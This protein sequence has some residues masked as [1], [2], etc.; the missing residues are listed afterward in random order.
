MA[1]NP[2]VVTVLLGGDVMLGRGVDQILPHPGKPQLRERYMR[3]ATGHVRL[4]ERVNGRIPLPVDWRW[5]WGEALAVLENTATDVCLI[6]LE[7]TITADG[8]FADRKPVCYRMHPD[9]VPALTALRPHVCALAN[10]HILDF[11]YQGLTDTVAALAGAGIQSV[12]AGADLLAARRSALVT[13][14]HER[15]VI[16]GSVAAES[17]GVPES[18]AARRDRP[19]VVDPGSGA[20]RRRRRCGGTG[21][22]GQTPRRYRHSLD[23]L[24]IQLGLCDRTRRRRVRAPTDRRRHR[25]GPRTFL[26]PSAANRDISR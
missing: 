2:D 13:V 14:G 11:G 24:G 5:P 7:T 9:N 21:A 19:G 22:G 20:T 26:A 4:A 12:G 10:N 1:G 23:A 17:S 15:R 8:E 18:W 16:V 3:D 6:N 25:H